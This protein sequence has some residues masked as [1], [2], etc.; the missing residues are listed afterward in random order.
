MASTADGRASIGGRSGPI[1]DRADTEL[2]HGLRTEVDALLIGAGTARAERY[3]DILRGEGD[4][5]AR[6]E[7][8]LA[9]EPLVCIASTRLDL[10]PQSVPLL[11]ERDARIAI[12][13]PSQDTLPPCAASVQYL[14]FERDG[15]LD[16]P[17]V[18]SELRARHGVERL[19]CEGGPSLACDLIA[20]GLIDELFLSFAP[21][22]ASGG[23]ALRIL[24]GADLDPPVRLS[25]LALHEHDSTLF[26]RYSVR[27]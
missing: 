2:L 15:I 16:L 11:D 26:M 19:L 20:A 24:A 5:S 21:Q 10:S 23:P 3:A 9:P 13:T 14:R 7:R 22:L 12:L 4:R 1:G 27:R 8:G 17:A 18:I 25:L 6:M